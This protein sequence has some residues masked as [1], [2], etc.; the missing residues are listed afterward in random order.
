MTTQGFILLTIGLLV[1]HCTGMAWCIWYMRKRRGEILD[2]LGKK[3]DGGQDISTGSP[4][5]LTILGM[6][7]AAQC[8]CHPLAVTSEMDTD[9]AM[10]FALQIGKYVN[11]L[12]WCGASEDFQMDGDRRVGW[13][14]IVEPLI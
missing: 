2:N 9:L 6:E 8:W 5:Y 11:A 7:V 12:R 3:A 1:G 10:V 14:E 4:E 13:N